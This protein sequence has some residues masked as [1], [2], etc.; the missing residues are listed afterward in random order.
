MSNAF[1]SR[2]G[3]RALGLRL[4]RWLSREDA[5]LELP[6]IPPAAVPLTLNDLQRTLIGLG[7]LVGVP[8][9]FFGMGLIVRWR[10]GRYR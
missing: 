1:L 3:N 2:N 5:L 10:R 6:P 8:G 7:A 4:L 9:L